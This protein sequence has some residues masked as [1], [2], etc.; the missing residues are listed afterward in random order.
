MNNRTCLTVANRLFAGIALAAVFGIVVLENSWIRDPRSPVP[1][2]GRVIERHPKPNVT[3]YVTRTQQ[4]L[5]VSLYGI[6]AGA[7][8]IAITAGFARHRQNG[9]QTRQD[10]AKY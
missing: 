7:L 10:G 8:V 1:A 6:V 5:D 3:V 2:A 4:A 9:R